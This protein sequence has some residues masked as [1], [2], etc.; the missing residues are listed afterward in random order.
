MVNVGKARTLAGMGAL[1]A[2]TL[3]LQVALT[4]VFSVAQ[5]YHFAF[6]IIS[7]ALLGFGASGSL[8]ALW[9]R[10][11]A[12][13][14]YAWY[15]QG[16][17]ITVIAAYLFLDHF[18]FDSYSIAWDIN[19]V[20]LL[21]AN[22]LAL[23]VPFVFAG[24]LIGS[25][26]TNQPE[27]SGLVYSANLLGSAAGSVAAPM[28]LTLL[29]GA[30]TVLLCALFGALAGLILSSRRRVSLLAIFGIGVSV[31]LLAI[32]PPVFEI[33]PSPYKLLS[34]YRLNPDVTITATYENAYERLDLI[35]SPTI[36]SA[37]GLSLAYLGELPPEAALLLDADAL[38][39]VVQSDQ[40]PAS[41]A[42][43]LPAAVALGIRPDG[44][45][46]I[47]GTSGGLDASV[48]LGND[49]RHVTI[50]ESSHQV[51]DVLHDDLRAWAGLVD[52]ARI[53]LVREDVRTY[54]EQSS[55]DYS[56]VQLPLS[57]NYRPISSGAFTLT[58]NYT[59]TA[60]AFRA[61]FEL[62]GED[63]LLVVTRWL[64]SPPSEDLRTLA[65]ILEML[66]DRDPLQHIV[67]FRSFQTVTFVVKPTPFTAEETERLLEAIDRLRY[68]LVLAP[69]MP[70]DMINRYARLETPVYHD[71]YLT[72]ATTSDRQ[73]FYENYEF[74]VSP[75]TDN[76]P[77]FFHFFRWAQTPAIV[78]NLGR[79]WQPFG[80]SGYLVLVAL[81]MFVVLA[82]AVFILAPVALRRAFR[83]ALRQRG[84]WRTMRTLV[85][86][87]AIGLAYLF[88]EIALNQ[89][90]MLILGQPTLTLSTVIGSLLLFSG[91][92]SLASARLARRRYSIVILAALLVFLPAVI[93]AMSPPVLSMSLAVR[94]GF[95]VLSIAPV[96]FLMGM[97]FARGVKA[98]SDASALIP[99]AWAVNG[100][101]SVISA[102]LA[103]TLALSLGFPAL[104]ILGGGLYLVAAIMAPARV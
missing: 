9:P 69:V 55:A 21:V 45:V 72:L 38:L 4:R 104:L 2:A 85:Y 26:L 16:F 18:A 84:T 54:A 66:G 33:I 56:I 75:P 51:F 46:L 1:S 81:L 14:L 22:L 15:A 98:L 41:F 83:S 40:M 50:V 101:A 44:D 13:T 76:H 67:A 91:L 89:R 29:G 93:D 57:D 32:F 6:L 92:G 8:L 99:W 87:A 74:E 53:T 94:L 97:P 64:H 90:Y 80:G 10:L 25:L 95:T 3:L 96:G 20:F 23:A 78:E 59:L 63:G 7:L 52:D 73:A 19:Q 61:Y 17:A 43:S 30:R 88:V 48:A 24:A 35:Q 100:S 37:P 58:E 39:P 27:S 11:K 36:H 79:R 47:L 103:A 28:F 62:C 102:V 34:Q 82:A 60:E 86:F 49:A 5:F 65:L 77:F 12:P 68:D 71:R 70:E 42:R 31:L